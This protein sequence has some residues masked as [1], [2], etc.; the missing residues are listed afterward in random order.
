MPRCKNCR[1]KFEPKHFNQK[2]C[3]KPECVKAWVKVA[4]KNNW[5][6]EKKKLKQELETVQSLTK[7]AQRYFNAFIRL[8]DQGKDCIS[9]GKKLTGKFDAGHYFSSGGHKILT[10]NEDNVHGQCVHCNRD[11]HGNLLEYQIGIASRIGTER[12]F[13]LHSEAHKVRKYTREEL[14]EI[15]EIYKAKAKDLNK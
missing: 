3:F 1:E 4:K 12:L 2:Y 7:K 14:R 11:L 6:K 13:E 10:F 9:C 5:K 8:R 15:I